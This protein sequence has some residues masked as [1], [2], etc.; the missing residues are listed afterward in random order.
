M[1]MLVILSCPTL[2]D[3]MNY[4]LPGTSVHGIFQDIEYGQSMEWVAIPFS[5]RFSRPRDQTNIAGRF[6][7]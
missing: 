3:P 7:D 1:K 2:W 6:T 5:S 4:K